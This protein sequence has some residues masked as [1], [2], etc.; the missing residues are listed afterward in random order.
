MSLHGIPK[1]TVKTAFFFVLLMLL[2]SASPTLL[3]LG[4][5][6]VERAPI[7][8]TTTASSGTTTVFLQSRAA[9]LQMGN[10]STIEVLNHSI[11]TS[12]TSNSGSQTFD[13][14]AFLDPSFA[15]ATVLSGTVSFALWIRGS[16]G[17]NSK[18]SITFNLYRA[19]ANGT[20]TGAAV[21]TAST[22]NVVFPTTYTEHTASTTVSNLQFAAGERLK[23]TVA[24]S[25]NNGI[26]YEAR[27]GS[28]LY[29][30]RIELPISV[31]IN[32]LSNDLADSNGLSLSTYWVGTTP[33]SP[34]FTLNL[35]S[36]LTTAHIDEIRTELF[37]PNGTSVMTST[38]NT[39][40]P[41]YT[42]TS[43][44]TALLPL[45]NQ[46][47]FGSWRLA[48]EIDSLDAARW[49]VDHPGD[50]TAAGMRMFAN[51]TVPVA[52]SSILTLNCMDADGQP[53]AGVGVQVWSQQV[54]RPD[55]DQPC[56]SSG[57]VDLE[58]PNGLVDLSLSYQGVTVAQPSFTVNGN[59]TQTVL[60]SVS[61]L[62][63]NASHADGRPAGIVYVWVVHPNGT[64]MVSGLSFNSTV[65]F[66]SLPQG[67]Y[68]VS[69]SWMGNPIPSLTATHSG[70]AG[71]DVVELNTTVMASFVL[72]TDPQGQP[73]EGVQLI[74]R[75][76]QTQTIRGAAT[77]L[78]NGMAAFDLIEANYTLEPVW[79]RFVFPS[80]TVAFEGEQIN[81]TLQLEQISFTLTDLD[82]Q[83]LPFANLRV[84]DDQNQTM[85]LADGNENGTGTLLLPNGTYPMAVQWSSRYFVLGPQTVS[86]PA[87]W[88]LS[89][90]LKT[91][92]VTIENTNGDALDGVT[93]EVEDEFGAVWSGS[94]TNASGLSTV[95]SPEGI[96][97][98]SVFMDGFSIS[99]TV[100][101]F[102]FDNS[103]MT[104][105]VDI[106]DVIVHIATSDGT[107]LDA[108]ELQIRTIGGAILDVG[109]SDENGTAL[110]RAPDG[111]HVLSA[112]WLGIEVGCMNLTVNGVTAVNFTADAYLVTFEAVDR[113]NLPVDNVTLILRKESSNVIL[114]TGVTATN[115]RI[116]MLLPVGT[117]DIQGS[118]FG[119]EV[120]N[121]VLTVQQAVLV[122]MTVEV[123]LVELNV[124]D[125]QGE[126]LN[127]ARVDL[128]RND[129][130]AATGTVQAN[131]RVQFRVAAGTFT[132]IATWFGIEVNRTEVA[133]SAQTVAMNTLVAEVTSVYVEVVDKEGLP[134]DGVTVTVRDGFVILDQNI[135]ANGGD[136]RLRLP[137][138]SYQATA[139]L[140][141]ILVA[142]IEDFVAPATG[143]VAIEIALER[144]DLSFVDLD[145]VQVGGIQV[146][147]ND[148]RTYGTMVTNTDENGDATL[149][150]PVGNYTLDLVWKGRTIANVN[151]AVPT[152][153]SEIQLPLRQHTVRVQDANGEVAQGVRVTLRD[154]SD[155]ILATEVLDERGSITVPVGDGLHRLSVAWAGLGLYS[156]I[157][158]PINTSSHNVTLSIGDVALSVVDLDDQPVANLG[159]IIRLDSGRL[160]DVV[161][162]NASGGARLYLPDSTVVLTLQIQG[163]IVGE[164]TVV[165]NGQSN[166]D[167]VAPIRTRTFVLLD[168][169]DHPLINAQAYLET[170][171]GLRIGPAVSNGNGEVTVLLLPDESSLQ[172]VWNGREVL[173]ENMT[174]NQAPTELVTNVHT[175]TINFL[176][177]EV[178]PQIAVVRNVEVTDAVTSLGRPLPPSQTMQV[179]TG[180][181][182]VDTVWHDV[183]LPSIALNAS[184]SGEVDLVLPLEVYDLTF[185]ELDQSPLSTE[186]RLELAQT[187]WSTTV[188][189]YGNASL[190]VPP[191]T[192]SMQVWMDDVMVKETVLRSE[193]S[194][195]LLSVD[196]HSLTLTSPGNR[197]ITANRL[198]VAWA[199][200]DW[201]E[202][203]E[204]GVLGP[205]GTPW[206]VRV[207]YQGWFFERSIT[208]PAR[209]A[210]LTLFLEIANV[211]LQVADRNGDAIEE[212]SCTFSNDEAQSTVLSESEAVS[213]ELLVGTYDYLCR[214]PSAG[215]VG[216]DG[217]RSS[218]ELTG[219]LVVVDDIE[220]TLR[221]DV[222]ELP[223][224]ESE[225]VKG[226]LSSG[227]GLTLGILALVGWVVALVALNNIMGRRRQDAEGSSPLPEAQ[228]EAATASEKSMDELFDL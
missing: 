164:E 30:S 34:T 177:P 105:I 63:L 67:Q 132:A 184:A 210:N 57:Q 17:P 72:V 217:R 20:V 59:T 169:A 114:A 54:R 153:V 197:I 29:Q 204:A 26:T 71:G 95:R 174:D 43:Q 106:P 182:S 171:T 206:T 173:M 35:S 104:I 201:H 161:T 45:N 70:Q 3:Q 75:D 140:S 185:V 195:V 218:K 149:R 100:E 192:V 190:L 7:S 155:N 90:P 216:D 39:S 183:V 189:S 142:E 156:E 28:S 212:T 46:S 55:L 50:A 187:P 130:F 157:Y 49:M 122:E 202:M 19:D 158:T 16:G 4:Q 74:A 127:G 138:G 143:L 9:A 223:F 207:S 56:G 152:A 64:L 165:I 120:L 99:S 80:M 86:G 6:E 93:V 81:I 213:F 88:T 170:S 205:S 168:T 47:A 221:L 160:L 225:Q 62:T 78:A 79:Q 5:D 144:V 119:V 141:G 91:F 111:Q 11:G 37:A 31:P 27:W 145:G 150:L 13:I 137:Y 53:L 211:T 159:V 89:V 133:F 214:V 163:I 102:D 193:L 77:T 14:A 92:E 139:T 180:M 208:P 87:S 125:T 191:G 154:P 227:V 134:V 52:A 44:W 176:T 224:S 65:T 126:P 148:P 112:R 113:S 162:T 135:S 128:L 10:G 129:V 103:T 110:L 115:G 194:T 167:L 22:S 83:S 220:N 33:A 222:V 61:D 179:V 107:P 41:A 118:W 12:D 175:V 226:I 166:V 178:K 116:D 68:V 24:V 1:S 188:I 48:L 101:T 8:I 151:L 18:A 121:T 203:T 25:G 228:P 94:M 42:G 147:A 40:S 200:S 196:T 66:P 108:V 146:L 85:V 215:E 98:V 84:L 73:I 136:L 15:T 58:V 124:V 97:A 186:L 23:L 181:H 199:G 21:A 32:V 209:N 2:Q 131:G 38:L 117:Y 82:G 123:L 109:V 60:T 172:V 69:A 51:V 219:T 76:Q 36:P 96:M 198:D